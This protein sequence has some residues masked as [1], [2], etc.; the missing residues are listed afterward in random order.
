MRCGEVP[1][2]E[3]RRLESLAMA[4]LCD[5]RAEHGGERG[6]PAQ[7]A[8]KGARVILVRERREGDDPRHLLPAVGGRDLRA[9]EE[10][11]GDRLNDNEME[12]R[13]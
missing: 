3:A 1:E 5:R 10:M 4:V 6:H 9:R 12:K 8:A 11:R 2:G 7:R 13:E